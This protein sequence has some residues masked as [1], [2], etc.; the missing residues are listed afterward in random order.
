MVIPK[1]SQ[2]I[3]K[4]IWIH[5]QRLNEPQP[6]GLGVEAVSKAVQHLGYVQIDTISVIERCHHHILY[7]RIPEYRPSLLKKAQSEEKTVFE[8][9]T[10]ALSYIPTADF[11]FYV[12]QMKQVA[13]PGSSWY[14]KVSSQDYAKVKRLLKKGPLSI[15]DI[16]DDVLVEKEHL[17]GSAKP[18]KKALQLGFY[19]GDFV[20]GE[21]DGMLKKYDLTERHFGWKT[22]PKS[23]KEDDY[24]RYLVDRA[25]RSQGIVSLDSICHLE[26]S[27]RRK[28]IT[29]LV[30]AKLEKKEWIQVEL[31]DSK[32]PYWMLP[33][34]LDKPI[35]RSNLAHILSPFDPLIIQRKRVLSFFNYQHLFEAYV[36]KEKRKYGYFTLPVLI[37]N[38]IEALLDLKADRESKTLLINSWVWLNK[39]NSKEKKKQIERELDR[40]SKFQFIEQK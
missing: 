15:R 33:E 1:I 19:K 30:Q 31:Q 25:L 24:N 6:F 2:E 13:S 23:L 5:S 37:G 40:F 35:P 38:N 29:N 14:K 39:S 12:K 4:N 11:K 10:H 21:R 32:S 27:E 36:P 7:N 17:W 3:A 34:T 8:Y 18:S 20:I 16:K 22:K 9:W 28:Q 26:Q